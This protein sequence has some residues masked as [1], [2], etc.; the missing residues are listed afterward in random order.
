MDEALTIAQ[1]L[2]RSRL[3]K[4]K[5]G[6]IA[7]KRAIAMRKK[8]SPEKIQKRALK[9]ARDILTKKILNNQDKKDLGFGELEKLDQKLDKK[10]GVIKKIAKKLLPKLKQAEKERIVKLRSKK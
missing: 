4:A 9:K 8:A 1:R 2:K 10:K 6:I 3:M 5:S 7:R